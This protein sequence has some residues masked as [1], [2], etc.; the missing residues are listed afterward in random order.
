M[1]SHCR[2][3][4]VSCLSPVLFNFLLEVVIAFALEKNEIGAT[5]SGNRI[6][7][8]R[9]ADDICLVATSNDDL[10]KLVDAVHTTSSRFGLTVSNSKT[11]VQSIG[12]DE[13]QTKI[14]LRNCQLEQCHEFVYLG[15]NTTQDASCD[16]DVDRM[17]GL[18]A[19]IVRSV[20]Q[21]E[22]RGY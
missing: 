21:M 17:I 11:V 13:Q 16:K 2:R 22:C 9:F 10:Q 5:I 12:K 4:N 15:G 20:H 6:S 3:S 19:G 8:L 14:M 18:A 1:V 7:N